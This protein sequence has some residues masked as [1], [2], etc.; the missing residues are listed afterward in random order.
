MSCAT[1]QTSSCAE[2]KH[3][4]FPADGLVDPET[5]HTLVDPT[6]K[7]CVGVRSLGVANLLVRLDFPMLSNHMYRLV[8]SL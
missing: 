8:F 6:G 2:I 3:H 7:Y 5:Q 1:Y 4:W